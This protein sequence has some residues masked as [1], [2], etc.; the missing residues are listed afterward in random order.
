MTVPFQNI[1]SNL[2]V[3]LFF[4]EVDNS[5]ANTSAQTQR[6]LL[7]GQMLPTGTAAANVPVQALGAAKSLAG[8]GSILAAMAAIY[9]LNDPTGEVWL[10]PLADDDTAEAATGTLTF[11]G[12][13]TATGVLSLYIAATALNPLL[14]GLPQ[15]LSIA[16]A[17]GQTAAQIATTVA[18]AINAAIDLP[19]SA[20]AALGVV[21]LTA[22]NKGLAG[23]DID[24]R[25]NYRGAAGGEQLPLGMAVAIVPMSGGAVNPVLTTALS[26]LQD[27]S[28]DFI[29][30]SFTDATSTAAIKSLLNDATGRWSWSQQ[31]YGHA[32]MALRGTSSTAAAWGAALNDQHQTVLPFPDSPTPAWCWAAAY[33]GAAARSLR[34]DPALP[35][36]TLTL[37]GVLAPPLETRFGL[38]IRNM[39]LY[40]G[41]STF[42]VDAN[43]A[44][45]LDNVVTT[46]VTNAAGQADD[47]YLEIETLFTLVYVLRRLQSVVTTKYARKKLADVGTRVPFNSNIVTPSTIRADIIAAYGELQDVDGLVQQA[48]VFAANLIVEKDA[49]N[50]NR[51]NVLFPPVLIGQLRVFAVLAQFRLQ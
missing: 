29:V 12:P 43:D 26:N 8:A 20:T 22:K 14:T 7:I 42:T 27:Q 31:V 17:S 24:I 3:G 1:P 41:C 11:T 47:S 16:I 9:Q 10:L 18:A 6:T 13:T 32:F 15:P 4:A 5:Q 33:A 44:V 30:S 45:T 50:T 49:Q 46:Y 36:Q 23:N 2:R 37:A 51:V 28:F 40:S 35:L 48:D 39:L 21:T 38:T 19:V 34:G 25:V